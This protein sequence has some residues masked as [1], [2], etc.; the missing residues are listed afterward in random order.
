M[1]PSKL[2]SYINTTTFRLNSLRYKKDPKNVDT[3]G[4][5]LKDNS[6]FDDIYNLLENRLLKEQLN[7]LAEET[8]TEREKQV[9]DLKYRENL[10][11]EEIARRL[12]ISQEMVSRHHSKALRTLH[13]NLKIVL[14]SN[15]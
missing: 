15:R 12:K 14:P 13:K 8:L 7:L 11:Q 10:T 4:D 6:S 5:I 3:L 2:V 1:I 9:V